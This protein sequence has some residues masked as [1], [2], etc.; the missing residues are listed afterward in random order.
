MV[1]ARIDD[2]VVRFISDSCLYYITISHLIQVIICI[3]LQFSILKM[4]SQ[5][6]R[7][8]KVCMVNCDHKQSHIIP[9]YGILGSNIICEATA[10]LH[11]KIVQN[12]SGLV[13]SHTVYLSAFRTNDKFQGKGYFSKLFHFMIDDLWHRGFTKATLG[14]EPVEEKNKDIYTHYGFTEY[15]KS[16]K[17]CYPDGTIIDVEYYGK[18]LE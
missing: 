11:P 3:R 14:V 6:N 15:I 16:G 4:K 12:S 10:M 9:Y 5:I 18:T 8:L 13:G 7:F 2:I 1:L 17:G